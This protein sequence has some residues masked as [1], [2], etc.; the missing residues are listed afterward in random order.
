LRNTI[1]IYC[2]TLAMLILFTVF[3]APGQAFA[4]DKVD[5]V[6]KKVRTIA[7]LP[8]H[9]NST[10]NLDYIKKGM[11]QMFNSRLSW[12]SKVEVIS[13]NPIENQIKDLTQIPKNRLIHKIAQQTHSDFALFCIV[14]ELSGSFSIDATVFDI[15]NKQYMAFFEHSKK[16]DDLIKKTDHIVAAINKKIFGRVTVSWKNMEMEKQK[17]IKE[18]KRQ[19]PENLI[20]HHQSKDSDDSPGWKIWKYLF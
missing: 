7:V 18:L 19:N 1:P 12:N 2:I 11:V 10:Q 5:K 4:V 3:F 17:H 8:V 13:G 15:E 16:I 14:T 6:D 9:V 20:R